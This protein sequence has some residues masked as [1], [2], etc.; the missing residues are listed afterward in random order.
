MRKLVCIGTDGFGKAVLK[1]ARSISGIQEEA[2]AIDGFDLNQFRADFNAF[3]NT[4]HA[5]DSVLILADAQNS[6]VLKEAWLVLEKRSLLQRTLAITTVNTAVVVAAL[7]YKDAVDS[8]EDLAHTLL[9]EGKSNISA[10]Y[11]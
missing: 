3:C 7:L 9:S 10:I 8:D 11:S 6:P 2:A 4:V 1:S 5:K